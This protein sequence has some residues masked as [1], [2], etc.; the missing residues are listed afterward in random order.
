M[1]TKES[2][3]TENAQRIG[4]WSVRLENSQE[5]LDEHD[6]RLTRLEAFALFT[7]G[8]LVALSGSDFIDVFFSF[9]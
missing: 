3:T 1:S 8:Y 7:L 9:I 5:R 2:D 4:Q 6:K